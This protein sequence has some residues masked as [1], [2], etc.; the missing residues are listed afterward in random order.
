MSGL[1]TAGSVLFLYF[2][3]AM[4]AKKTFGKSRWRANNDNIV[5]IVGAG[6]VGALACSFSD[7]IW[8]SAVEGE[9][10][11]TSLFFIAITF[12]GSNEME[13]RSR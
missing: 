11:A 2:T 3:I 13:R 4:I 8:F 10:Y 7:T 5:A 1:M 6:A 9:V 12:M